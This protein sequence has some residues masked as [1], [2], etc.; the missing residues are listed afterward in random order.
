VRKRTLIE[1]SLAAVVG[2]II[3]GVFVLVFGFGL[4]RLFELPAWPWAMAVPPAI[5]AAVGYW[6]G[7]EGIKALLMPFASRRRMR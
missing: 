5:G 1:K 3:G 4:W 6:R 2:G 7:D